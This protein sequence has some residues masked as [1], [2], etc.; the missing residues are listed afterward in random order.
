MFGNNMD[1]YCFNAKNYQIRIHLDI[2]KYF[3]IIII[4]NFLSYLDIINYPNK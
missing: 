3:L 1:L 4:F 2:I